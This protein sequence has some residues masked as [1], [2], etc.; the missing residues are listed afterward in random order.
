MNS[1]IEANII[2]Y[3]QPII[4][5]D[6]N[7]IYGYEVLGRYIDEN[8]NVNS[9]GSFFCDPDTNLEELLQV[10]RTIREKAIKEF[11][12]FRNEN[13]RLFINMRLAWLQDFS[14]NPEE[15]PTIKWAKKYGVEFDK[16]VIEI[17]EEDVNNC[18]EFYVSA[19]SYYRSIGMK[20]A[21]DDYGCKSSNIYRLAELSPDIIKIDMSFIHK[22]EE[23]YQYRHYLKMLTEF[24]ENIGIEVIYEGVENSNQLINCIN[25]QGRFYQGFFLSKPLPSIQNATFAHDVFKR[26]AYTA[27][28]TKQNSI[29]KKKSLQQKI[30]R[31]IENCLQEK[32]FSSS[33]I[34]IDDYLYDLCSD[35]PPYIIRIY[36]CNKYGFQISSNIEFGDGTVSISDFS[37]RNW[38]WRSYFVNAFKAINEKQLSYLTSEYRDV[39]SKDKIYTYVRKIDANTYMF[40]D[41]SKYDIDN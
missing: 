4:S 32:P 18:E 2:P 34:S 28:V 26:C 3:F 17:T 10:D 36:V 27:I 40:V 8:K 35:I 37:G 19:L 20:I 14:S 38:A 16:I 5:I 30:D 1:F 29:E 22:S 31:L 15:M 33:I 24:A 41:I 9:L 6:N 12:Q 25:A 13:E 39:S 7:A 11:S 23:L 21:I